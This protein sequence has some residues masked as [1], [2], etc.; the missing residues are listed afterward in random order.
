[1]TKSFIISATVVFSILLFGVYLFTR[2]D[3]F[4]DLATQKSKIQGDLLTV[5]EK[6]DREKKY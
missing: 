5:Q 4:N 3:N 1:M 2:S 6:L